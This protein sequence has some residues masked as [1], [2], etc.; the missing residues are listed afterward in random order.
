MGINGIVCKILIQYHHPASLNSSPTTLLS[1]SFIFQTFLSLQLPHTILPPLTNT[2]TR[3]PGP[4]QQTLLLPQP[5]FNQAIKMIMSLYILSQ[6]TLNFLLI[7]TMFDI[8]IVIGIVIG[9]GIL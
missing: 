5:L 1:I 4:F 9:I 7:L 8:R 6:Y 2:P 3:L